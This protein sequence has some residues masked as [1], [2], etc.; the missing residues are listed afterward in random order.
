MLNS[1]TITGKHINNLS[2]KM[3]ANLQEPY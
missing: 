1:L 2:L 3:P